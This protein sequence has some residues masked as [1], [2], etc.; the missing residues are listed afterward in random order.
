MTSTPRRQTWSPRSAARA[1]AVALLLALPQVA[2]TT[3]YARIH[4]PRF[5]GGIDLDHDLAVSPRLEVGY[6]YMQWKDLMGAGGAA[7]VSYS[8]VTGW[9]GFGV[10][11]GAWLVPF[12]PFCYQTPLTV[13]LGGAFHPDEGVAFAVSV[14]VGGVL[15]R[16]PRTCA[17][18][19]EG[20]SPGCYPGEYMRSDVV[21]PNWLPQVA[22]LATMLP[23]VSTRS[24][25]DGEE[26][27][28]TIHSLRFDG[29]IAWHLLTGGRP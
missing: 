27:F 15:Y 25:P 12:C 20:Q 7:V 4:G 19:L 14:G 10:E 13:R 8:P 11:G 24:C 17:L 29:T 2:C 22:Y 18:P 9:L 3:T 16:P 23:T 6:Q 21:F 28:Q 26:C 1:A 5:G